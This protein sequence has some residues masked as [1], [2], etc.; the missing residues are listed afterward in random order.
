MAFC[1][2]APKSTVPG[3]N[4][5]EFLVNALQAIV[6]QHSIGL[7]VKAILHFAEHSFY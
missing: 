1:H 2:D 6:N 4:F 7:L 5:L 3:F